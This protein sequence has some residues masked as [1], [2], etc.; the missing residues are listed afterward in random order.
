M[1]VGWVSDGYQMGVRWVSDQCHRL[2]KGRRTG[3][4]QE[5]HVTSVAVVCKVAA[6]RARVSK[7]AVGGELRL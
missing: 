4:V 2:D 7:A 6:R 1:G 5:Q 3:L